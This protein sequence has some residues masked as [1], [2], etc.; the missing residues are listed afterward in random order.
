[1][2]LYQAPEALDPAHH[3][4]LTYQPNVSFRFASDAVTVPLV[5]S[6]VTTAARDYVVVFDTAKP[7]AYALL[8]VARGHNAYVTPKGQ[9]RGRYRPAAIR[10]YPFTI[11]VMGETPEGKTRYAMVVD[12]ASE[13]VNAPGGYLLFEEGKPT[14]LLEK[15]KG[16]LTNLEKDRIRL[17]RLVGQLE[18]HGLLVARSLEVKSRKLGVSGFRVV[19]SEALA[20]LSPEALAELRDS[21]ALMLAYAQILSLANLQDSPVADLSGV[22][23]AG[24][25]SLDELFD[26]GDDD[27]VFDFDS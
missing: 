2:S 14:A 13:H 22:A 27:F 19:D 10:A 20:A 25:L 12:M 11:K 21:G 16:I 24:P 5:A 7:A 6:E 1:M 3:G 17:T 18:Q 8:G 26:E 23:P 9:W 15:I 4:G